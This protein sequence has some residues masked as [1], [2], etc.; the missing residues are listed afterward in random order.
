MKVEL[1]QGLLHTSITMEFNGKR[2]SI[3]NVV[4]DTGAAYSIISS[5]EVDDIGVYWSPDDEIIDSIGM[6]GVQ[7]SFVKRIDKVE[8]AGEVFTSIP[9]D[10]GYFAPELKINGLI[11]LDILL[12]GKF[13]ID[14]RNLMIV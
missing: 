9:F 5:D 7:N 3:D 6:G 2:K 4:I 13:C 12:E 10:F 14:L 8:F 11:G 1:I